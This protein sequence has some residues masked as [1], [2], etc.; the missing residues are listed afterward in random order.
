[1]EASLYF[2]TFH[3]N[4]VE[5]FSFHLNKSYPNICKLAANFIFY[6]QGAP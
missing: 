4:Y 6:S 5:N 2:A 3:A 1:M